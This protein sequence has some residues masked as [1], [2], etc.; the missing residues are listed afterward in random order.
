MALG[1][2]FRG[3]K[4]EGDK[5]SLN[6]DNF[7]L[8]LSKEWET[9]YVRYND[10]S[11]IIKNNSCEQTQQRYYSICY[12][13]AV[14]DFRNGIGKL[15]DRT[16]DVMPGLN[17]T[18]TYQKPEIKVERVFSKTDPLPFET[19]KAT[20]TLENNGRNPAQITYTDPVPEG[21]GVTPMQ[22]AAIIGKRS[23]EHTSELSHTDISYAVFCLKK[24]KKITI[25]KSKSSSPT[26]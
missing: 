5:F 21:F 11:L 17:I 14:V 20:I 16:G 1:D 12:R 2:D 19:I 22:G 23:E 24:K 13:G 25:Q 9:L 26:V 18:M 8:Q 4:Y 7:S 3:F 15:H 10:E 6:G